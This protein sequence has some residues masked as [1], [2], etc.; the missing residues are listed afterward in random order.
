MKRR[1]QPTDP[2]RDAGD[3]S[4]RAG[5][6]HDGTGQ[7]AKLPIE[8]HAMTVSASKG[9]MA[10]GAAAR[11]SGAGGRQ[12]ECQPEGC[13]GKAMSCTRG[14]APIRR[15]QGGGSNEAWCAAQ[16]RVCR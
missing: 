15:S 9:V 5:A 16:R 13:R 6:V 10:G 3:P 14:L 8:K 11:D 12:Y 2:A 4:S 1:E 7:Q